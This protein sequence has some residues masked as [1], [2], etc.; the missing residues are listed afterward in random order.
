MWYKDALEKT[1]FKV[2]FKY[3]ENQRQK[4]KNRSWNI[5]WFNPP[6]NKVVKFFFDWS[7]NIF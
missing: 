2:D 1:G 5:I 7:T 6:F 4:S 3:T